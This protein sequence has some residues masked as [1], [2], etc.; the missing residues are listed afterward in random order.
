MY[1]HIHMHMYMHLHRYVHT[2]TCT[3]TCAHT[4]TCIQRYMHTYIFIYHTYIRKG[5]IDRQTDLFQS[6]PAM[7]FIALAFGKLVFNPL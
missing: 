5:D 3:C 4:C 6:G 2:H 1:T 7:V